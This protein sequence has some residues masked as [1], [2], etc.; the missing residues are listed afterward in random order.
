MKQFSN[1]T[2]KGFPI[3]ML[4]KR[5]GAGDEA[6]TWV[7]KSHKKNVGRSLSSGVMNG[8]KL[9]RFSGLRKRAKLAVRKSEGATEEGRRRLFLL[10]FMCES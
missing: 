4:P 1:S 7:N 10:G 9:E 3:P 6:T 2:Q 5:V 8:I